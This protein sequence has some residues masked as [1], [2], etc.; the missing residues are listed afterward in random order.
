MLEIAGGIVIGFLALG[1]VFV[2]V[3][4]IASLFEWLSKWIALLVTAMILGLLGRL[5]FAGL[6]ALIVWLAGPEHAGDADTVFG[7]AVLCLVW[8]G[9]LDS[10]TG[11]QGIKKIGRF[12]RSLTQ[13][14]R[15]AAN[16]GVHSTSQK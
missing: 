11:F 12:A 16:R 5:A 2:L 8:C 15:P 10:L 1:L 6:Y 7:G 13:R 3:W 9:F 4:L 14:T